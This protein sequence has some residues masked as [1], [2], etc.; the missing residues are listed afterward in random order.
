VWLA[1]IGRVSPPPT[2]DPRFAKVRQLFQRSFDSGEEIG[3]AAC[4]VLDGTCVIDLWEGHCDIA[5][6][7][8]WERD[9]L[10]NVYST[11]KV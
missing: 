2:C 1:L 3:A 10:V 6:T 11:T 4:F 5:R 8:K 9:T 7:R